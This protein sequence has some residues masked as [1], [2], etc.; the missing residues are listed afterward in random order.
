MHLGHDLFDRARAIVGVPRS[1]L[2]ILHDPLHEDLLSVA[3]VA[4]VEGS[5]PSEAVRQYR[6]SETAWR[7]VTGPLLFEGIAA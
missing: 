3:V 4:L 1:G 7:R 6:A 5:D 2:T